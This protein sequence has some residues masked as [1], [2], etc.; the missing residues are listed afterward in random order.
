MIDRRMV[1]IGDQSAVVEMRTDKFEVELFDQ[2]F[3]R[4]SFSLARLRR[5]SQL[6]AFYADSIQTG[7]T[8]LIIDLGANIG[9]SAV[10]FS[11]I[12]S[13]AKVLAIEPEANNYERLLVN[14]TLRPQII[15]YQCAASC[16]HERVE[17]AN[18]DTDP[19]GFQTRPSQNGD[20]ETITIQDLLGQFPLSDRYLPFIIKIDIEGYEAVLFELNCEWIDQFPLLIAELHDWAL[21][22]QGLSRNFLKAMAER[23]RDFVYIGENIFSI[24]NELGLFAQD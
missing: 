6:N 10:Y 3:T 18:P 22:S 14:T 5:M 20:I 2:I 15:P 4:Q 16:R 9:L 1:T 19:V 13:E 23:D 7:W 21:P 8:P 11:L 12:W 24:K 17:I